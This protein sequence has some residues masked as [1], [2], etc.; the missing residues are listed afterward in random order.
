MT[1]PFW[2]TKSLVEM[3][4]EEW[5]SLCDGCGKCCLLQLENE[6]TERLYFTDVACDLLDQDTCRCT[7]YS[8]RSEKVPT[9]MVMDKDN[10]G[11]CAEFA[12]P[13]CA[14]RLLVEG[15]DL[16]DWHPLVS[17]D[18]NTVHQQGK[19]VRNKVISAGEVTEEELENHI[20]D[21]PLES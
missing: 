10:V 3:N 1:E 12:P 21:W 11:F 14:Y 13:T 6:E 19:S 5:E 8:D 17:G 15:K 18:P 16:Y 4:L 7:S 9:C 20:V 2:K